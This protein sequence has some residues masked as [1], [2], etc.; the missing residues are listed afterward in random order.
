M[1]RIALT[2]NAAAGK[3]TVARLLQS[4]GVTVIDADRIVH[5][6]QAPGTPLL[7]RIAQRFGP[8]ILTRTGALDRA[9]LR[10]LILA[11]PAARRDLEAM[12]HPA[13]ERR[14]LAL[15]SEAGARGAAVVVH[16]IPLLFEAMDP[17]AFDAVI[18]VDAPEPVRRAR[19]LDR[20]LNAQEADDLLA[21][22]LPSPHK[23][24][25]RGGPRDRPAYVIE[26]AGSMAA[27]EERLREV[28]RAVLEQ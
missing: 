27:L 9:R 14:R 18:L 13:V 6:L 23:R 15:E 26:N 1:L 21:A 10:S 2:G 28:W 22:Q 4:W 8:A 19:L 25:W 3:S 11:E 12:V 5:E 16:D 17:G 7:A 24:A 20:G